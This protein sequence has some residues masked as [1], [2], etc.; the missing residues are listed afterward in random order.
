MTGVTEAQRATILEILTRLA[1]G[2]AVFVFGS[3]ATGTPKPYSDLD[4]AISGPVSRKR[5][6]DLR[7]AFEESDLPFR[8]D[9]IDLAGVAPEFRAAITPQLQA[10]AIPP[11]A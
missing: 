9:L 2:H 10:V 3:R 4:L 5:I 7:E 1:P 6:A 11:S 8:V